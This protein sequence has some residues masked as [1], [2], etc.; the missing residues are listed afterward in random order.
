MMEGK[1]E[2]EEREEGESKGDKGGKVKNTGEKMTGMRVR[3][4]GEPLN[5]GVQ[6][7][8]GMVTLVHLFSQNVDC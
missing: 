1:S 5:E 2:E 8:L 4:T 3:V 7:A 6:E